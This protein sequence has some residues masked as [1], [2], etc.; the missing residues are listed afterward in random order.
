MKRHSTYEE[1]WKS[2][3]A[4]KLMVTAVRVSHF[5]WPFD[6]FQAF[7]PH[8][9]KIRFNNILTFIPAQNMYRIFDAVVKFAFHIRRGID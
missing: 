8:S 7:I 5:I 3:T 1:T 2:S 4:L 9:R 6:S